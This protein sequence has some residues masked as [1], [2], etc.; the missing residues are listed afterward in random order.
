MPRKHKVWP[1]GMKGCARCGQVKLLAN[2]S[3]CRNYFQSCCKECM[4]KSM[5]EWRK[6]HPE[7]VRESAR[8]YRAKHLMRVRMREET[9]WRRNR[10]RINRRFRERYH[11]DPVFR[12]RIIDKTISYLKA[13][14]RKNLHKRRDNTLQAYHEV[15]MLREEYEA[16][17]RER[18]RLDDKERIEE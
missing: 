3:P 10:E 18:A 4:N 14:R 13:N 8:R 11:T 12:K 9:Y 17:F 1:E 6:A 16:Y 2:F 7:K 15:L 5:R